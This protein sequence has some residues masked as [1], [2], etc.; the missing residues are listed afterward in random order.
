MIDI[1]EEFQDV[2]VPE[3]FKPFKHGRTAPKRKRV[4]TKSNTNLTGYDAWRVMDREILIMGDKDKAVA[5]LLIAPA[6]LKRAFG[7]PNS[8]HIGFSVTGIYH[9]ED[10]NLSLFA[11]H[12]YK[13]TDFYHG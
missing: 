3:N 12:D 2:E 1:P 5:K 10:K 4:L 9:F 8:S 11:L 6:L 13:Q 7:T